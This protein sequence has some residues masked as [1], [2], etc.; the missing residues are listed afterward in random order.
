MTP[1]HPPSG[2]GSD[3]AAEE[4][5]PS[6][7]AWRAIL[8]GQAPVV[9]TDVDSH[10]DRCPRCQ[11]VVEELTGGGRTWLGIAD[12]LRRS[13]PPLPTVCRQVLAECANQSAPQKGKGASMTACIH[14]E[15][16]MHRNSIAVAGESAAC[17]TLVK[18]IPAGL[19]S[20]ARPVA[21]NLALVVDVSG[22]MYE[23][24]GT[25][26]SRIKRVQDSVMTALQKL[27]P[28]DTLC[29]I[30][31][32]HNA[33]VLLPPTPVAEKAK[34]EDVIRRL[35]LFEI[36]PGGTAM[37]EALALAISGIEKQRGV[38]T[39]SQ[40]VI[41]T[42]G[43]TS[44]EENCR[45]LA[46]RAAEKQ[47]HLTLMGVGLDW[48]ASLIKDL[49]T[50]SQGKWYYIDVNES[51]ATADLRSRVRSTGRHGVPRRADAPS[52]RQDVRISASARSSRRS[53][54]SRS[55]SSTTARGSPAWAPW[56]T[57]PQAATS[58]TWPAETPRM[59]GT[60]WCRSS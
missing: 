35:D 46:R 26:V 42:D 28:G 12:E 9:L 7:A 2:E 49:A 8:A 44:G 4:R 53:R 1:I 30:G 31:F 25:G 50:L 10:L 24:D 45:T 37:D 47:I 43:E 48:K 21:L 40:I 13:V 27:Q 20:G 19:G 41:L 23:E 18:L 33:L 14:V 52:T 34:I 6:K 15:R 56:G 11:A 5:C 59:A 29:I 36:D 39:L 17:Y 54:R 38:G 3:R 22:S 16:M 55:K 57:T 51:D 58:S 60:S 32:A